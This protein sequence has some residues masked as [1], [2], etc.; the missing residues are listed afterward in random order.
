VSHYC[1]G[2]QALSTCRDFFNR[3]EEYSRVIDLLAD[4][5]LFEKYK[6]LVVDRPEN[7][8]STCDLCAA[9]IFS[10][11]LIQEAAAPE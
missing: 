1:P 11:F 9:E 6:A 5:S 7:A 2:I 3:H 4:P 10:E 8:H